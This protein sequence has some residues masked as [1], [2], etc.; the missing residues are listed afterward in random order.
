[1]LQ[2]VKLMWKRSKRTFNMLF[3]TTAFAFQVEMELVIQ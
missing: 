1:M 2:K 3:N